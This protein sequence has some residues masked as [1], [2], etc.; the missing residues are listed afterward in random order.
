MSDYKKTEQKTGINYGCLP[1]LLLKIGECKGEKPGSFYYP[2]ECPCF[3]LEE[4]E[5]YYEEVEGE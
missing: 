4:E 1:C 3:E 5:D 2:N